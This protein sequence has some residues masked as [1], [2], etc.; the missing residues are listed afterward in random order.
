MLK[1]LV[2]KNSKK[3]FK[4]IL[5]LKIQQICV[6]HCIVKNISVKNNPPSI[7]YRENI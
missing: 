2:L 4:K 7:L 6:K 3:M 5:V 1:I